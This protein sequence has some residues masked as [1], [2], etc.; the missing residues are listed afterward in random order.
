MNPSRYDPD[1]ADNWQDDAVMREIEE[2]ERRRVVN[3]WA[4]DLMDEKEL[5]AEA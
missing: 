3:Q 5:L 1:R 2:R 4:K